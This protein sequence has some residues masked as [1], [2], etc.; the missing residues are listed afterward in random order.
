MSRHLY[1]TMVD[2]SDLIVR[3]D[4]ALKNHTGSLKQAQAELEE[5]TALDAQLIELVTDVGALHYGGRT[6]WADDEGLHVV[7]SKPAYEVKLRTE[8]V[9]EP[10]GVDPDLLARAMA[11]SFVARD[12]DEQ[13]C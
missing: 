11:T 2:A 10:A 5:F 3:R 8:P 1:P 9:P 6:Y 4:I 12:L 13:D 7:E